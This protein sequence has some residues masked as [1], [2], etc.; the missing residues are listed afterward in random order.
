[1]AAPPEVT[2]VI[3][4]LDEAALLGAAI[5]SVRA[6]AE[7]VVVDGGSSDGT[8]AVAVSAGARLL[9]TRACRGLQLAE[10]ARSASGR[11]LVFLH[12]DTRLER[13]WRQALDR[14]PAEAV[15]GAFRFA[16]DSPRPRYRALEAAVALR[17]RILR[18]P[19]GDQAIFVRRSAYR[20]VGG[21]PPLPLLEDVAFIRRLAGVGPLAFPPQRAFTSARRWER[22]GLVSTTLRNWCLLALYASG[23]RPRV[24]AGPDDP[25]AARVARGIGRR[26]GVTTPT[27]GRSTVATG[28]R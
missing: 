1:M 20:D 24:L 14:V 12:A 21:F 19:Y 6:D 9:T 18:L 11:W 13:G 15:G 26:A 10:G 17:C 28:G 22:R 7:V 16:V 23:W 5:A 8:R 2:V 4:A 27:D 25:S 3:P